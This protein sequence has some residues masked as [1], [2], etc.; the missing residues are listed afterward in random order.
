[1]ARRAEP[2]DATLAPGAARRRTARRLLAP[3]TAAARG[4]VADDILCAV[5][6]WRVYISS[7][8]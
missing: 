7:R 3:I 5:S 8:R 1:M 6:P 4:C 2:R